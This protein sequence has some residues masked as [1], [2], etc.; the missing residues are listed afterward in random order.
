MRLREAGQDRKGGRINSCVVLQELI[1]KEPVEL[2]KLLLQAVQLKY[3]EVQLGSQTATIGTSTMAPDVHEQPSKPGPT[4]DDQ[5]SKPGPAMDEQSA[6]PASTMDEQTSKPASTMGEQTSK[7]DTGKDEEVEVKPRVVS[8]NFDTMTASVLHHDNLL[9]LPLLAGPA[10]WAIV[11]MPNGQIITTDV[12]NLL[13]AEKVKGR[14]K[15]CMKRPAGAAEMQKSE[16]FCKTLGG[17]ALF[18]E[19]PTMTNVA[20]IV[21]PAHSGQV[22]K[23]VDGIVGPASSAQ[24]PTEVGGIVEPAPS[25]VATEVAGIAEPAPSGAQVAT[26]TNASPS[27]HPAQPAQL[28]PMTPW[29][30]GGHQPHNRGYTSM[31]YK[32][33]GKRAHHRIAI[34]QKGGDQVGS[35]RMPRAMSKAEGKSMASHVIALL[36]DGSHPEND[37]SQLLAMKLDGWQE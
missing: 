24:V 3:P 15:V 32:V 33:S 14:G 13:V 16:K 11:E 31:Y 30:A 34:R 2:Q 1:N 28:I 4:M 6:K 12:P 23:E 9:D 22:P 7:L 19:V 5:S 37:S 27:A 35:C 26:E 18:A 10:S 8:K 21:E 25:A 20:A 29:E 17:T 36:M